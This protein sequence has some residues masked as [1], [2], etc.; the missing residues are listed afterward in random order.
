MTAEDFE[1]Q[2]R[3][4]YLFN[5]WHARTRV[6][7]PFGE[8]VVEAHMPL[9]D[10]APP[11]AAMV[12]QANELVEFTR[13]YPD[14]ILDKIYEHYQAVSDHRE[15]LESCGVPPGLR[16]DELARYLDTLNLVVDRDG[17]E[18]TIYVVP[19][20]DHEHAI[21]L[22]VRDGRVEFQDV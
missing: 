19:R 14:A 17:S 18:P 6:R 4:P 2:S 12:R 11:D 1:H 10:T 20:W 3:G 13:A 15:W 7:T 8:F 5:F 22:A 21:Y 9:E 16:R